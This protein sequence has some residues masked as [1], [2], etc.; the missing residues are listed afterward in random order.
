MNVPAKLRAD[1]L[2][3]WQAGVDAACSERLVGN[4]IRRDGDALKICEKRFLLSKLNRIVVIGAG[5]AGA[6]MAAAVEESLGDD[7]LAEKVTGWVN[8]PADCL[9]PL[10]SIHLHAA[11]PAGV[12]EPT[13]EGVEGSE[14]I[15]KLAGDLTDGDL[16]LVLISGGGSALAP[17]PRP[18]I[19]LEDKQ[20]VTR[21]LVQAGA[22]ITELNA[23][24]KRLSRIKGGG[25]ARASRGG[26]LIAL[27]I[28]DIVDDP[29]DMIASG[30]TYPDAAAADEPSAILKRFDAKPP[31][32]P[33]RVI[34]FLAAA[35]QA[36]PES[37]DFPGNVS[38]HVIGNNAT[39]MTAATGKAEALGYHVISLGS[40]N[41]GEVNAEGRALAER[42]REIRSGP[43]HTTLPA[44]LLSGGEPIVHL[45]K[46]EKPRSGGRNQ[47]LV[48]AGLDAL[49]E[50]GLDRIVILSAG[51]DGEDGPTDA[52][53]AWA[54]SNTLRAVKSQALDPQ[55]F[56]EIND[57]YG[58]FRQVG[59]LLKTGPTH[60][61]VMDL[62]VGLIV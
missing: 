2:A 59:G 22:T 19:T 7:V 37:G 56:L 51:T 55:A 8:V 44:C 42:C 58:F 45:A 13:A 31:E 24:R 49:K 11:R 46:T 47:Q 23:V 52:A 18:P 21:F 27:I 53:G 39:A 20:A 1:A 32:V 17:A 41:S 9:R 38:N 30:P 35:A 33:R 3:I 50:D 54:D 40:K 4:V 12:N 62:R 5:K 60:T 6:G 25:L 29:L 61:N 14:Q 34:E 57:S 43:R 28:S 10:K 15:L 16:C 36:A 48:L 26:Q